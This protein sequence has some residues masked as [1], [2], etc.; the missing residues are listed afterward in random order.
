MTQIY[1]IFP[2]IQDRMNKRQVKSFDPERVVK[3]M[4]KV[5]IRKFAPQNFPLTKA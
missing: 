5:I 4:E 2:K 3:K 1:T